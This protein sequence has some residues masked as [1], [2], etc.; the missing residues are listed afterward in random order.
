MSNP[1]IWLGFT[2]DRRGHKRIR[3]ILKNQ[4]NHQFDAFAILQYFDGNRISFWVLA[5]S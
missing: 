1:S 2:A 3:D 5:A 4:H